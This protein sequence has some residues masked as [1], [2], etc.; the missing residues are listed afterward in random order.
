MQ[1]TYEVINKVTGEVS[2]VDGIAFGE[3]SVDLTV[4]DSV[5]TFTKT[6]QMTPIQ[7]CLNDEY[8]VREM[9]DTEVVDQS[10]IVQSEDVTN[11]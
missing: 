8:T 10:E 7:E 4:G 5:I 11:E 6:E 2:T 9:V 3:L 1:T